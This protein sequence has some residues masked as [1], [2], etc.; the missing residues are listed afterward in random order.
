MLMS[1]KSTFK[2]ILFI[3]IFSVVI[4]P[5]CSQAYGEEFSANSYE[6]EALKLT[7]KERMAQGLNPLS[8]DGNLQKICDTRAY[9]IETCFSHYKPDGTNAYVPLVKNY[10]PNYSV[11]SEN[12]AAGQTSPEEVIS[13]WM[14]SPGHKANILRFNS[15]HIGIGYKEEQNTWVQIFLGTCEITGIKVVQKG[16]GTYK[17]GT[18]AESFSE[19]LKVTC[20]Q[21]GDTFIPLIS[22]M[23]SGYNPEQTGQQTIT[24]HYGAVVPVSTSAVSSQGV[25]YNLSDISDIA[26]KDMTVSFDVFITDNGVFPPVVGS[27]STQETTTSEASSNEHTQ[28]QTSTAPPA[29]TTQTEPATEEISSEE[30]ISESCTGSTENS[31]TLPQTESSTAPSENTPVTEYIS[32][33]DNIPAGQAALIFAAVVSDLQSFHI[34][35]SADKLVSDPYRL[36]GTGFVLKA[37]SGSGVNKYIIVVAGDVNSDGKITAKDA[38]SILRTAA[39]LDTLEDVFMIAADINKD[40][41]ISATDARSALRMSAGL[42]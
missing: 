34:Y 19:Y 29:D 20:R 2:I 13:D 23:C 14:N 41:K 17:K 15:S 39:S 12:I 4:L 26:Y 11:V 18:P 10:N 36:L 32:I 31:T 6:W 7:N 38:R 33:K 24:V 37:D 22:E 1:K 30:D 35:D 3:L 25:I 27:P 40:G 5:L 28:E 42:E 21:H 9:E 16:A 8:M